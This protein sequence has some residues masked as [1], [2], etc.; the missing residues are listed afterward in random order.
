[1]TSTGALQGVRVLDLSRMLPGPYCSMILADHGA[2]VI[3]IEDRRFLADGLFFGDLNRNKRHMALNLKSAEGLKIFFQLVERADVILEGFRPGVV[4]RLGIDYEAVREKNLRIV[5]CSISGYG[6]TG[7][8]AERAGHD[9]NYLSAA[10]VLGLIGEKGRS[11]V[12]PGVQLA[13]I[14][15]GA[16]N[17]AIGILLALY[18]RE[19]TGHGQSIDISMTDGMVGFLSLPYFFAKVEGRAP[20]AGD[21][22]L[23]HRFACYNTY[24]TGDGRYLALG[25]VENRFWKGLCEHLGRPDYIPLQYDAGCR[26]EIIDFLRQTFAGKSLAEW[27]EE[28]A[29]VD[30]CW[31][32]VRTM[33][34]VL[35][36]PLFIAREMVHR[37]VDEAGAVRHGFGIPVK[38]SATPGSVRT[39]PTA[40]GA[41]TRSILDE[42]GY[43]AEEVERLLAAGVV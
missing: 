30:A 35:E 37:Y 42:L 28:L 10:G 4:K 38:L 1:M 29:G 11:P 41:A 25:A 22:L 7:P 26:Q 33:E 12:I 39:H 31:S 6:Q 40:F 3:A 20:Q 16:M 14:A 8:L 2:E 18:A 17:A 36:H 21:G 32:G 9:V 23:A 24:R 13:D 34:E 43:G 27:E 5:Y 19:R 15:G